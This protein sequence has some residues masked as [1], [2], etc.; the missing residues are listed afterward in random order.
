MC[1]T[2]NSQDA[3]TCKSCGFNLESLRTTYASDVSRPVEEG[4]IIDT[5]PPL[6]TNP[7]PK[8]FDANSNPKPFDTNPIPT[9]TIPPISSGSPLFVVSKSLIGSILP[10]MA[11]L[12]FISIFGLFSSP[13]FISLIAIFILISVVP[14]LTSP[15]RYEFYDESLRM[16]KIVGGDS[17][18]SYSALT[19]HGSDTGARRAQIVVSVEGQRRPFV[20]PG[21]PMNKELGQDLYQFL[22]VKLKKNKPASEPETATGTS[23]ETESRKL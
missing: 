17:D 6:D 19:L 1:G 2:K 22:S 20:I 23:E 15:R 4:P 12:V 13:A 16:H 9:S 3:L 7:I 18:I 21:N 8:P 5:S 11:Y 14:M 10:I